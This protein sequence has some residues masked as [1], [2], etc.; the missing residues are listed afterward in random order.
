MS[1]F[2]APG[3]ARYLIIHHLVKMAV[4]VAQGAETGHL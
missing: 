2:G 1:F 4:E 3:G